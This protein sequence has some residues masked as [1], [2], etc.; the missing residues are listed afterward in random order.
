[1]IDATPK[2]WTRLPPAVEGVLWMAFA[3][4]AWTA[5]NVLIRPISQELPPVELQ[6]FRSVFSV[7]MLLPYFAIVGFGRLRTDRTGLL[8][9]RGA[10]MFC[11]MITWIYAVKLTQIAT[12]SAIGFT[13]PLFAT[14]LAI[15]ILKEK[16]GPRRW[17]AV[18]IGFVGALV[19]VR[20]GVVEIDQGALF[21]VANAASW[22]LAIIIGRAVTRSVPP[23]V[24]VFYMFACLVVL[25]GIPT[26]FVWVTPSWEMIG[27]LV[28]LALTGLLGHLAA[29]RA[30][31]MAETS[32]IAPVEYLSL[33]L[34]GLAAYF[35]FAEMPDMYMPVGATIIIASVLYISHREAVRARQAARPAPPKVPK[36]A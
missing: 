16:V 20:P 33:P 8:L 22:A 31:A 26:Y 2:P 30:F 4:V 27:L 36:D 1:M 14:L 15:V 12:A 11:S 17:T 3:A 28:S 19:I 24:V 18:A 29:T 34:S 21:A 35:L 23:T 6:F 25:A 13:A 32:L 5:N 7:A 9:A 10:V